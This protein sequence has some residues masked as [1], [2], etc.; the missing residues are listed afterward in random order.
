MKFSR[1]HTF[2]RRL[3]RIYFFDVLHKMWNSSEV[4]RSGIFQRTSQRANG[5]EKYRNERRNHF[6]WLTNVRWEIRNN[7]IWQHIRRFWLSLLWI[8][9]D[10]P[11]MFVYSIFKMRNFWCNN[12]CSMSGALTISSSHHISNVIERLEWH[13]NFAWTILRQSFLAAYNEVQICKKKTQKLHEWSTSRIERHSSKDD[14]GQFDDIVSW[15][16]L[17]KSIGLAGGNIV[18]IA[19]I[20]DASFCQ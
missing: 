10:A 18:N 13:P 5:R 8:S 3:P 6:H 15:M 1:I 9:L 2:V 4:R 20:V 11:N 14:T 17:I 19:M 12:H 16:T 7:I